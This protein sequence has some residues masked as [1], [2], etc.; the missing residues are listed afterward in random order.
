M[1]YRQPPP[2]NASAQANNPSRL[3]A[4]YKFQSTY[5]HSLQQDAPI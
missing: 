4:M 2:L 5:I 3:K 1:V